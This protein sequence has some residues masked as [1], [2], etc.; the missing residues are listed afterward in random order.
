MCHPDGVMS[1]RLNP[2]LAFLLALSA[3]NLGCRTTEQQVDPTVILET[4]GGRE[5]GVSTDYGVVFL[6]RTARAGGV[7]VAAWFGDGPSIEVSVIEPVGE[8]I[9]TADTDIFLPSVA[10]S[11]RTPQ[12]GEEVVIQ[13]R[14]VEGRWRVPT[15]VARPDGADGLLLD[16]PLELEEP[17]DQTGAGIFVYD[18]R[19]RSR[20]LGL[21][22][23]RVALTDSE[24]GEVREYLTAVGPSTLWRLV[25]FRRDPHVL[26]RLPYR[27]DIR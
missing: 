4:S 18:E 23:G 12:A 14:D 25:S 16:I 6:G 27:D 1:P 17:N 8:G 26:K 22:S 19:G 5:L 24:T 2:P 13:G 21:L 10:L 11:F 20:L 9:F 7:D 15:T 3:T